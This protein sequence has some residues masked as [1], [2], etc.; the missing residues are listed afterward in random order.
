MKARYIGVVRAADPDSAVKVAIG[1]LEITDPNMQ[2]RLAARP[3]KE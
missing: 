1:E 2:R 3:L